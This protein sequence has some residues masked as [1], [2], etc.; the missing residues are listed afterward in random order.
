MPTA[1]V[2]GEDTSAAWLGST[3]SRTKPLLWKTSN[4]QSDLAIRDGQWKL[5]RPNRRGGEVELYDVV[6]D[7]AE[8][9]NLAFAPPMLAQALTAKLDKWNGGL[10]KSYNKTDYRQD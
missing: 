1:D 5:H 10:P 6:A 4:P 9:H 2:D 7:P 3:L 8:R